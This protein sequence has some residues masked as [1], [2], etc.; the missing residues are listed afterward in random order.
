MYDM[1]TVTLGGDNMDASA[2]VFTSPYILVQIYSVNAAPGDL[3]LYDLILIPTD[4]FATHCIFPGGTDERLQY[5]RLLDIDSVYTKRTKRALLRE[6]SDDDVTEFWIPIQT[7][8]VI[9]QQN[10]TQRL[11]FLFFGPSFTISLGTLESSYSILLEN[12]QR[13]ASMRGDR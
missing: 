4:E 2:D 10:A 12:I 11:W 1:G 5:G 6:Y 3:W 8:P 9:L 7:S 13:Y